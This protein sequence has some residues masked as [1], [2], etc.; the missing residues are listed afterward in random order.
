MEERAEN[1]VA[2]P[3]RILVADDD[4]WIRNLLLRVLS[5]AGHC[6]HSANDGTDTLS[7]LWSG[8]YDLAILDLQ[9]SG[10][11]GIEVA[12]RYKQNPLGN[13]PIIVL[14]ADA[15]PETAAECYEAGVSVLLTKPVRLD[16]LLLTVGA[17]VR[18][19]ERTAAHTHVLTPDTVLDL[20]VNTLDRLA[21]MCGQNF[22]KNILEQFSAHSAALLTQLEEAS[23]AED[24]ALVDELLH[25]LQGSAGTIGAV[26]AS[27]TARGIRQ[28]L[29]ESR[30]AVSLEQLRESIWKTAA[31]IRR[32]YKL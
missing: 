17:F 20:D 3:L 7:R 13:T 14:T 10:M 16:E 19:T 26:G 18:T 27:R 8:N 5:R 22:L 28:Q 29:R 24:F 31:V 23:S 12:R 1:G 11:G 4:T 30:T 21:E 15:T 32:R 2:E 9:M 25:K 6:L